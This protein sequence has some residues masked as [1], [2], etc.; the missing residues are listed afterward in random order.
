MFISIHQI[1]LEKQINVVPIESREQLEQ[2]RMTYNTELE[3]RK[4]GVFHQ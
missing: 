3:I 2:I 4:N 1:T